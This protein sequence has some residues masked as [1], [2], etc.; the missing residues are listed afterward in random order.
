MTERF[1][2]SEKPTKITPTR[3]I[4][5]AQS[6]EYLVIFIALKLG[7]HETGYVEINGEKLEKKEMKAK[8][9][10]KNKHKG[11]N[12]LGK[13]RWEI[14]GIKSDSQ[15]EIIYLKRP[16]KPDLNKSRKSD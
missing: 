14:V 6:W 15:S 8:W 9:N 16:K 2:E 4:Q 11:L 13:N 12:E 10:L 3:V 1:F 5:S 7:S